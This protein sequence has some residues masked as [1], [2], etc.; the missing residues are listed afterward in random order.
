MQ[1]YIWGSWW[2]DIESLLMRT[3][4]GLD[5]GIDA[6]SYTMHD[7]DCASAKKAVLAKQEKMG[8]DPMGANDRQLE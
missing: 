5:S 7:D 2:S 3:G 1:V 8:E 6:P 4:S